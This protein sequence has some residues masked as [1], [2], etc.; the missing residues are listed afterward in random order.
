M[1]NTDT[2]AASSAL[3]VAAAAT[4]SPYYLHPSDNPGALISSVVLKEDNYSEWATELKNSLQAKKKL[5]FI[6]GS[7]PKPSNDPDLSLWLAANSMII[8]WIRPS[9]DPK[10]RSTVSFISEAST[11]WESLRS[12][13]S[14]SN[15]GRKQVLK[16]EIAGCKQNGQPVL[17]YY[18]RL[19]KLWEE[20]QHYQTGRACTCAAAP[21]IAKEREDDRVHQFLFGLDIPRFSH[22]R[23]TITGEDP[24]PSLPQV[25]SRVIRE[26][27]NLNV[28]HL[29][30][31]TKTEAIG[32]T[33]KTNPPPQAAAVSGPRFRD[34]STLSCTHC[35]RQGHDVSECFQLHGFPEWYLEQKGGSNPPPRPVQRGGRPMRGV[36]RG[37]GRANNARVE[38]LSDNAANQ[39]TQL[40]NLLQSQSFNIS[41]EKLSGKTHLSDVVLDT[42]AS[43]HMTGD[44]SILVDVVDIIPSPV[45]KPDGKPSRAT[46]CGSLPLKDVFPSLA[47]KSSPSL[48]HQQVTVVDDD[49]EQVP[50]PSSMVVSPPLPFSEVA[51]TPQEAACRSTQEADVDRHTTS[52]EAVVPATPQSPVSPPSAP[53]LPVPGDESPPT[54][55][56]PEL[57]GKG[58]RI[59]IPSVLLKD[60][61]VPPVHSSSHALASGLSDSMSSTTASA[62]LAVVT[63]VT[64]FRE[65]VEKTNSQKIEEVADFG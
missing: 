14:V 56:L 4:S 17:E 50:S 63:A 48:P 16:D 23:S 38:A 54:P 15:A 26:E 37:R 65:A 7:T 40:I 41:S 21:D 49:W 12:R 55:G 18:G 30:E 43:H 3:T 47:T 33:V 20:L 19:S 31:T 9:I 35:R 39:I 60:Y 51:S 6:D 52:Q 24:L 59:K 36:S 10:I 53:V 34:R 1:S 32:F 45:T 11:L 64:D 8:G 22:I 61:V 27:Q 58:H 13:F 57:L 28:S 46:K 25:Y 44:L 2:A 5:G 62:I 42:G 29:T